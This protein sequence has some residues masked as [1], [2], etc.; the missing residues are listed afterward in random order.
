MNNPD[1]S[2]INTKG[3]GVRFKEN[4]IVRYLLDVATASGFSLNEIVCEFETEQGEKDNSDYKQLMQLIGYSVSGYGDLGCVPHEE[5]LRF[6]ER[7]DTL[8]KVIED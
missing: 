8:L 4:R 2:I 5:A 3:R 6:D 1:Q 7:A